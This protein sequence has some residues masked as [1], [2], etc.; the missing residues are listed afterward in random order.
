[1]FL[2]DIQGCVVRLGDDIN[3]D[4]LHPAKYFS[5]GTD[6]VR[7]G[8]CRGLGEDV[9]RPIVDAG[10]IIFAGRN[11]GCGSSREVVVQAFQLNDVRV[12]FARSFARIFQRNCLLNGVLCV[13]IGEHLEQFR[14]GDQI[15]Y[16]RVGGHLVNR[17]TGFQVALGEEGAAAARAL[18]KYLELVEESS[19]SGQ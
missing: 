5:L 10:G 13:P 7:T 8:F 4:L 17:S 1:M 19:R 18:S 11:F 16:T 9:R 2:E 14:S 15:Y 3:T 12:V 6:M